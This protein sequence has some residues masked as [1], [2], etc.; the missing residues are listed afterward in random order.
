MYHNKTVTSEYY[1]HVVHQS[2]DSA[3]REPLEQFTS[4]YVLNKW[5]NNYVVTQL[6]SFGL[7]MMV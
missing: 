7:L 5:N 3:I 2:L 4:E 6:Q 1:I